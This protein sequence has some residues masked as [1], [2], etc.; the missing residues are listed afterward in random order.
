[1]NKSLKIILILIAVIVLSI[2]LIEY[3]LNRR[4]FLY[5]GTLEVTK[6]DL[7]ARLGAAIQKIAVYEGD[8]VEDG[9]VLII[10][11]CD[12]Y[13]IEARLAKQNYDRYVVLAK[14]G[15][16]TAEN[17]D[18]LRSKLEDADTKVSWCTIASPITGK[19]LSRY[20]E[21]GEW[22]SP[23]TKILT[24]A[25]V[26]DIWAYIY[27]PQTMIA[28]LSVGMTLKA[29]L[30]EMNNRVFEG[31]ILKINE[32]AEFTPKNVQTRSERERL[33][34]GVKISFLASNQD[35]ILKPGMTV[36]VALP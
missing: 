19:V 12:D 20:H 30:P 34:Y 15:F 17:M 23:G 25:N 11:D 4:P 32:E 1:M 3:V 29:Y 16:T 5:A 18:L 14:K 24:L 8:R 31:K 36:E 35:E 7:S 33:V 22:M 10:L 27:V 2:I 13:K 6:V 9:E 26:K 28:K 21:P